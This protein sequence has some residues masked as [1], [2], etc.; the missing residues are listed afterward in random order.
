MSRLQLPLEK[1][2]L[3]LLHRAN[4]LQMCLLMVLVQ[5]YAE[6]KL[7][8]NSC[9]IWFCIASQRQSFRM[10][11]SN[12]TLTRESCTLGLFHKVVAVSPNVLCWNA[13]I[14]LARR[15][16]KDW[17]GHPSYVGSESEVY[18]LK[19]APF[20]SS[21]PS[22]FFLLLTPQMEMLDCDILHYVI[23]AVFNGKVFPPKI[24]TKSSVC[25]RQILCKIF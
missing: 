9:Y 13:H 23:N 21:P 24:I 6:K 15:S 17:Q 4:L 7:L 18:G 5:D 11:G 2:A 1:N 12:V 14:S 19:Q 25:L 3:L 20:S 10:N 8:G 22:I 16:A